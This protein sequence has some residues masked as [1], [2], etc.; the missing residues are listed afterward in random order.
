MSPP[1]GV[2]IAADQSLMPTGLRMILELE[3]EPDIDIV[4]EAAHGAVAV[5]AQTRPDVVLMDV[6]MP[7]LDG[8]EATRR[9]VRDRGQSPR[10]RGRRPP[11]SLGPV[12]GWCRSRLGAGGCAQGR[13]GG[14]D[15]SACAD[16]TRPTFSVAVNGEA[17]DA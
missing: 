8:L 10:P 12:A 14:Q 3:L 9:I 16:T 5:V 1:I 2:V 4:G 13:R 7:H 6:R 17:G 15:T 11:P